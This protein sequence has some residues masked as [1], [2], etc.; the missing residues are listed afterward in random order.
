M[1]R[2]NTDPSHRWRKNWSGRGLAMINNMENYSQ[3]KQPLS[4]GRKSIDF[5][6]MLRRLIW[7]YRP[8]P[9]YK[10][11]LAQPYALSKDQ[12]RCVQE[13]YKRYILDRKKRKRNPIKTT[14]R[15]IRKKQ[16]T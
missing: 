4:D 15:T 14:K 16:W 9:F 5:R 3:P 10:S 2:N 6:D 7:E 12:I 8:K 1:K 11:L 13:D